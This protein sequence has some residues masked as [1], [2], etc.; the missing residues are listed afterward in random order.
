MRQNCCHYDYCKKGL[1]ARDPSTLSPKQVDHVRRYHAVRPPP[2]FVGLKDAVFR[3]KRDP[4]QQ[5]ECVCWCGKFISSYES[6]SIHIFGFQRESRTQRPCGDIA[7]K[8]TE[9]STTK[10]VCDD[11]KLPINYWP[12]EVFAQLQHQ[13]DQEQGM[14]IDVD[15]SS[16]DEEYIDD[17]SL[18]QVVNVDND[19]S[20]SSEDDDCLK[21]KEQ[22]INIAIQELMQE[23]NEVK[24]KRNRKRK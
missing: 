8:A 11:D 22:V 16:Q 6:L 17:E 9:I 7:D 24:E 13:D 1:P 10:D 23:L 21:S 12:A 5:N 20:D 18:N 2:H 19:V 4:S 14:S 3:F 15:K